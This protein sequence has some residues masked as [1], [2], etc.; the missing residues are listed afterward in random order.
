MLKQLVVAITFGLINFGW[1]QP[2]LPY[3]A[4]GWTDEEAAAHLLNRFAHGPL[5]SQVAKVAQDPAAWVF[6]QIGVLRPDDKL[7]TSLAEQHP[8]LTMSLEEIG[9]TYPAPG[10]RLIFARMQRAEGESDRPNGMMN[11]GPNAPGGRAT[12]MARDSTGRNRQSALLERIINAEENTNERYA[13][14]QQMTERRFGWKDFADLFYQLMAQKLERAVY[15]PNQLEEIMVDF[16]FNHFNV[17]IHGVN[18]QASQVLSYER[19]AIRPHAL[20]NFRDLLGATAH[21]P[22]MLRYLDNNRSNAI[23]DRQTL[24]KPDPRMI[25]FREKQWRKNESLRQFAQH[26]GVNEN[27]ARELLELHTLGVDGG[28]TQRDIEEVA[29]CLPAGKFR[30]SSIRC[31]K[32]VR[33]SCGDV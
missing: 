30:P 32:T 19:D 13:R 11:F 7:E 15:S 9:Q 18:D 31:H 10:V 27:Y 12:V 8:A 16:W 17:S 5:P 24:V 25:A 14:F 23:E 33:R 26:P 20:G 2:N 4:Q 1:A 3:Q 29:G 6:A 22:A 21:H 28:Y